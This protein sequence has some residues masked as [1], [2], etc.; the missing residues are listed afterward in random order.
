MV[1]RGAAHDLV[2]TE[3]YIGRNVSITLDKTHAK[4]VMYPFEMIGF[5]KHCSYYPP[6]ILLT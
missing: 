1:I 2:S 6:S 3:R 4:L 5:Q